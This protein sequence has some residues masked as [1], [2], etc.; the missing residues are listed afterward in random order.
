[1]HYK[2]AVCDDAEADRRLLDAL[3][4]RWA[5]AAGHTVRL[6]AFASAEQFLF[7]YAGESD[8]DILP[9]RERSADKTRRSRSSLSPATRIISPRAMR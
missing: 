7:H 1:M 8:Y 2:I 6:A 3:V 9:W 5:A 4:R